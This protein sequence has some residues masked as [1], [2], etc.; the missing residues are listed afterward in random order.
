MYVCM[1]ACTHVC[2]EK[3]EIEIKSKYEF[4]V[5]HQIDMNIQCFSF[6]PSFSPLFSSCFLGCIQ[7]SPRGGCDG[8]LR[9]LIVWRGVQMHIH[10]MRLSM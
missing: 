3:R 1:Y 4:R 9:V 5:F 6:L 8:A 7:I 10:Y 2:V